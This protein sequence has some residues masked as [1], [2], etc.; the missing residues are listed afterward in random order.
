MRHKAVITAS[1][2][3]LTSNAGKPGARSSL[4]NQTSATFSPTPSRA[5]SH[6]LDCPQRR[7]FMRLMAALAG[8]GTL[9]ASGQSLAA[10]RG[11]IIS[12][13]GVARINGKPVD[14][15]TMLQTGDKFETEEG[16]L[17][18]R[19]GD[20]AF[21]LRQNT[22]LHILRGRS[23][24]QAGIIDIE[25]GAVGG[26]IQISDYHRQITLP[27]LIV[28]NDNGGGFYVETTPEGPVFCTCFGRM[29]LNVGPD[30]LVVSG[31]YHQQYLARALRQ[32]GTPRIVRAVS[33]NHTDNEI[34]IIGMEADV[35]PD[36]LGLTP[37]QFA[38]EQARRAD[39][40]GRRSTATNVTN[41]TNA[42]NTTNVTKASNVTSKP[43]VKL[44]ARPQAMPEVIP[45]VKPEA[46]P[47][48]REQ[49]LQDEV[50]RL[51]EQLKAS[52]RS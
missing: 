48:T 17:S 51:R 3:G 7:E 15:K 40:L 14:S 18:F 30:K 46:K 23:I 2:A 24:N 19:L 12:T 49:Q 50:Q 29:S 32:P 11:G 10:S 8:A 9:A 43:E 44:E 39:E 52:Q 25:K 20:C 37:E 21:F 41:V 47:L 5:S 28:E 27:G 38:R 6:A 42:T 13:Y 45:E 26:V 16:T 35:R 1:E 36:W 34:E 22:T 33:P 31:T 4:M